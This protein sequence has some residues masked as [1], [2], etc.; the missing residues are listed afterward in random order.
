MI[1]LSLLPP[2][3]SLRPDPC[4]VLGSSCPP[5]FWNHCSSEI[6][7]SL[8]SGWMSLPP[9]A[10]RQCCPSDPQ[11]FQTLIPELQITIG[12]VAGA[13]QWSEPMAEGT[14]VV[15]VSCLA[16]WLPWVLSECSFPRKKHSHSLQEQAHSLKS[17]E[18]LGTQTRNQFLS[19]RMSR[20]KS[21]F[22]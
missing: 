22:H 7:C 2:S 15:C 18:G 19:L 21:S 8:W 9:Q 11:W 1:E 13:V 4:F 12:K 16:W 17:L 3:P 5:A 6:L 20:N 14:G 10:M